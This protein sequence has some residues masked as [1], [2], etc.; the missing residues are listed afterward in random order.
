MTVANAVGSRA[1]VSSRAGGAVTTTSR[2]LLL[3][4][5]RG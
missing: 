2:E 1:V 3:G 5:A 4:R